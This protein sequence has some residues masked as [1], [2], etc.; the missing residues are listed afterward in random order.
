MLELVSSLSIL[1]LAFGMI[2][3]VAN[4]LIHH[5]CQQKDIVNFFFHRHSPQ[6]V[7]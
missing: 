2:A 4:V 7:L 5:P 3:S 1:L 6:L